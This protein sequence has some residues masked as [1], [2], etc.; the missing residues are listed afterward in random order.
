MSLSSLSFILILP[1]CLGAARYQ[2]SVPK[3]DAFHIA[4]YNDRDYDLLIT[5]TLVEPPDYRDTY[6]NLRL[7]V[8]DVDTGDGEPARQ[9]V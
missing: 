4:F 5:G 2:L 8:T 3:F 9:R 6:T 1:F 7:K